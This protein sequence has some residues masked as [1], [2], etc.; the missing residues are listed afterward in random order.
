MWL[1]LQYITI[2]FQKDTGI[3]CAHC[4]QNGH[5]LLACFVPDFRTG[6]LLPRNAM[7]VPCWLQAL[8]EQAQEQER[9]KIQ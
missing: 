3:V 9:L 8:Y 7:W 6:V 5:V 1:S 4:L 2:C